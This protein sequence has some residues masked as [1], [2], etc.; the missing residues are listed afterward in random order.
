MTTKIINPVVKC[1][2]RSHV[3]ILQQSFNEYQHIEGSVLGA[4][5]ERGVKTLSSSYTYLPQ[6][7]RKDI[8]SNCALKEK[9][10]EI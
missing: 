4:L 5:E 6:E 9:K 10:K 7:E 3:S 8:F 2:Q 1:E